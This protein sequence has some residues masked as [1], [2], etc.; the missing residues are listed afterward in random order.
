MF[1]A[2]VGGRSLT[3]EILNQAQDELAAAT[4]GVAPHGNRRSRDSTPE[5]DYA[6]AGQ[7][8]PDL[9]QDEGQLYRWSG[10]HWAAQ[11]TEQMQRHAFQ[12]LK[13]VHPGKASYDAANS[14][15]KALTLLAKP[16]PP[17]P[18]MT[19]VP[20]RGAWLVLNEVGQWH[21]Q[22][23][24]QA[25]G[26][27]HCLAIEGPANHGPYQPQSVPSDSLFGKFLGHSFPDSAVQRLVADFV[28][29]SLSHDNSMHASLWL[30]GP[31]KNGKSVMM[32]VASALHAKSVPL[33]LDR[34]SGFNLHG[35]VGAS[36]VTCDE[37][38]HKLDEQRYKTLVS[39]GALSIERKFQTNLTYRS[40]AKIIACGNHVPVIRDQSNGFWRRLLIV[41]C[42]TQVSDKDTIVGLERKI[43]ANELRFV[44]D[45]ALNGL[46]RVVTRGMQFD[47]P[48]A[49]TAA[50]RGAKLSTNNVMEWV[51]VHGVTTSSERLPKDEVYDDYCS[52][53]QANGYKPLVSSEFF[54]RL[55]QELPG[56]SEDRPI[57]SRKGK[58]VRVRCVNLRLHQYTEDNLA[59]DEGDLG[60][61]PF[62][63]NPKSDA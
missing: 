50:L 38:P 49:C 32:E 34:L 33:Q 44:L 20:L 13:A 47:V 21:S 39:G 29:Y 8:D 19:I 59:A 18:D 10:S 36:L 23:P 54:K 41:Q 60:F 17:V 48:P 16:L 51:D 55:R 45:W 7:A 53:C 14:C 22:P 9:A 56:L 46:Q 12:W 6:E 28:G 24:N 27:R 11:S 58:K 61:D 43:V 4:S 25:V 62:S 5:A 2:T 40:T 42:E 26:V 52:F 1:T 15:V 37:L 35:L 63:W 31:G 57:I 30:C 3:N